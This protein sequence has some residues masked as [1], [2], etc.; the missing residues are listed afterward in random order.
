M[1]HAI[2]VFSVVYFLYNTRQAEHTL[3]AYG[4]KKPKAILRG[5]AVLWFYVPGFWVISHERM[6]WYVSLLIFA[7][8]TLLAFNA[9]I[10]DPNDPRPPTQ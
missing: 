4:Y 5:L 10:G 7:F 8:T 6:H 1:N 9:S 3:K 2:G